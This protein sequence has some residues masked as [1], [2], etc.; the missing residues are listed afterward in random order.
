[1]YKVFAEFDSEEAAAHAAGLIR[2]RV[3]GVNCIVTRRMNRTHGA[4]DKPERGGASA[5]AGWMFSPNM[6]YL[7]GTFLSVSGQENG[8]AAERERR[9]EPA[10]R[11][12]HMLCAEGSREAVTQA[13][14]LLR[15]SGGLHVNVIDAPGQFF[16]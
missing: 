14:H 15:A 13:S 7:G 12:E 1:M 11:H 9:L 4:E 2:D 6:L 16:N 8:D 3:Q 10:M 5:A